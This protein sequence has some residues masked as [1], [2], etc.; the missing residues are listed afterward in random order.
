MLLVVPCIN[1]TNGIKKHANYVNE[2]DDDIDD[3]KVKRAICLG[4]F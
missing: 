1:T 3:N 4:W 2:N